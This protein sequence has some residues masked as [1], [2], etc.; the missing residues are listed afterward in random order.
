MEECFPRGGTLK[1]SE[2]TATKKRQ[3]EDD[4]LFSTYR[5]EAEETGKKKKKKQLKETSKA[6][7]HEKGSFA[8][9]KAVE[10][11]NYKDLSV[12]M[13]F[14]GCIKE[15]KD[16]ELV[17]SLPYNLVGFVQATNICE[18][19][20][21]LLNEQVKKEEPV[22]GLIP[23]PNL[24]S[25]GMLVRC[26]ISNLETTS[27]GFNSIKLSLNPKLIHG[28]LAPSSV[29][30]GMYLTGLVS[31][32][33]DHGYLIDLGIAGTKAFLPRHKADVYINQTNK[34]P[35]L[36]VGQ[37]LDTVIDEVKNDGRILR[38]SVSQSDVTAA[39][40]T[41]EQ[42]WTINNLLPGLVVKAQ[43]Q[44]I[45]HDHIAVS[46]LSSYTGIVDFLHLEPKKANV[47]QSDQL[48]KACILWI[49]KS[50]KTIRLTFRKTFLQ[51]GRLIKQ[52]S[53][54][55]IGTVHEKCTVKALFKH[56]GAMFELDG[57][58]MAFALKYHLISKLSS[59]LNRYK[60]G[61]VHT[62]RVVA[63]S[64]M[65][66]TIL[67]SL[68]ETVIEEP[69][70]KH[71]DIQAGQ[72]LEGTV[73]KIATEGITVNI[74]KRISG[75]IPN[76]HMADITLNHPEKRYT[77]GKN[78]KCRVLNVDPLARKLILTRKKTM[79]NSKLPIIASF[80][81]AKPGMITHG[82]IWAVK[83]FGCIV[84]FYNDVHG[85]VP[86]RELSSHYIPVIQDAFYK[87]QV[88]R[89][90][91]LECNREKE[92]LLLSFKI[93]EENENGEPDNK[94][95]R[96]TLSQW[97]ESGKIVDVRIAS[98]TD[99]ELNVL[100]L[101]EESP[102]VLPKVHLSDHAANCELLF[103][104]LKEGDVLSRVMCL[105][106]SKG[107]TILTRKT[108]L[109]SCV[110]KGS[111]AKDFSEVQVGMYLTGF[112][113]NIM[114]YGVF[115]EF[116]HGLV[117]LVP[118]S[119]VSDKFVTEI[120][121]HFVQGQ[122]VV[123]KVTNIDEQKK[124]FLLTLKMS[125]CAP[126]DC[127]AD[128]FSQ[129]GQCCSELQFCKSLMKKNEKLDEGET[130]YSVIPG[131]NLILVVEKL[132]DNG[133]VLFSTSQVP[134][135]KKISAVQ[136]KEQEKPLTLGQKVKAVILHVDILKAHVHVSMEEALL[137]KC[138]ENFAENSVHSAVIQH[139]S[140]EFAVA[141]LKDTS[142]LVA[143][144]LKRHFNDTFRFE[145]ERLSVGQKISVTLSSMD[146]DQHGI[147]FAVQ[148]ASSG[149]E[150]VKMPLNLTKRKPLIG[151]VITGTV[152]S[153][154]PISV[155]VSITDKLTGN[156][157][158]SQIVE[159][160]L[161]GA[162]PTSKLRP[163]QSVTCRVI[164]GRD[165][166]TH[167]FLP[168]THPHLMKSVLELSILPSLLN[169]EVKVEK[170]K[171]LNTYSSGDTVTCYVVKYNKEK[172]CLEVEISPGIRGTVE[173]LL[174]SSSAKVLKRPEK[175]F[176][177]G[178]AL[179]AT[180]VDV[181]DARKK[182]SLSLIDLDAL[183][184]GCITFGCVKSVIPSTGLQITIPF[185][186]T[187]RASFFQLNDCYDEISL[188]KFA[189]G[190]LVRCCILSVG[191]KIDL[192]LRESRLNPGSVSKQIDEDLSSIDCLKEG[193]LIKGFVSAVTDKGVFFRISSSIDGHIL[194]KN[195]TSYYVNEI[196]MY[197]KHIPE[198]KLLTAK[199][200]SIAKEENHIEL[201][202]LSNDTGNPDVIPESD[203]YSLRRKKGEKKRRRTN[204][205]REV[206]SSKK[207]KSQVSQDDEDSGVEVHY[208]EQ[209]TENEEKKE[210]SNKP[211]APRLQVSS[212]FSWDVSLNTLKTSLIDGKES[213][214]DS[215]E[216]E[217]EC[218]KIQKTKSNQKKQG[219]EKRP[220]GKE[221]KDPSQQPQSINEFERLVLSSPNISANWIQ[222][223]D[224]HLQATELEQ[225]RAV[226]ER[227]LQT[228]YFRE[229]QEKLNVWVA[230]L[231]MENT[232]G[233]EETLLK[234]F[235]RAV[236]YNDP[237]KAFQHLVEIYIK[238]EKFKEADELF[239]TMIKR[240]KQEKSVYWKNAAFLLKQGQSEA[241]HRLL[242]RAMKCLPEKEHV[243]V[244]SK[245]AQL[246][247]QLGDPVRA[248]ALF[249]STLSSYPKRT[250][251]WSVYID[252]MV[253]HGNQKEI[254]DIFERV[255]HLSLA[256]KRIKFFFKRYLE[257]EKKHGNEKTVQAVKEKALQYVEAKSS[258]GT[259]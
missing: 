82:F 146:A 247:F 74:A 89:V 120:G 206:K 6:S 93:I 253:K 183:T 172:Q 194:F 7:Q 165:L 238:S 219:V 117:G 60:E 90:R 67:L 193:Q 173:Q 37:Y 24:Y 118:I 230:M 166:K 36:G 222:Y 98:K 256:A 64:P 148:N 79:I 236:Q 237:L 8:K 257:Y 244:I 141:S 153:I 77:P 49:D 171:P 119:E 1:K 249:E 32:E 160:V 114:P 125:E 154:K 258:V 140:E 213:S 135:A 168:I 251:I 128:G 16:F 182:L 188:E 123:A 210:A 198:G 131:K 245:F 102:A 25:P 235:G 46:F 107:Q 18:A 109:I 158:A 132:E 215:E 41:D 73:E 239:N 200:I 97:K 66:E 106:T 96:R 185:G 10:L 174:L 55:W 176:R 149:R 68:K 99:A 72:F 225:A 26:A 69:F 4:N 100:I 129:I 61:T 180:V 71:E 162:L 11:L 43:I 13:L 85:L 83:D 142:K 57:E 94:R 197:K 138:K 207:K 170:H 192:S 62:G 108:A 167:K 145:S 34:G 199:I 233:T 103:H 252:M 232:Y 88:V 156:I 121:D 51:P 48:V 229:E 87:G 139:L 159:N 124:R 214:S 184:E 81:D 250:D 191:N 56:A 111:C 224:F 204:S 195:V 243:E 122:T 91:V 47:Y 9:V 113:R 112:V 152:K 221:A 29:H 70:W 136:H 19:Y 186:K 231:N 196:E 50:S 144:P 54:N 30:K 178:Q 143:V 42:K 39:I 40:A 147:Q 190:M 86:A 223:M 234:V 255:I 205:E 226:A 15:V 157:H 45:F 84:K 218:P 216:D 65:E 21:K 20:T 130:I 254:R 53:S 202:L 161:A 104:C 187:G 155:L 27:G 133:S 201:S 35:A 80:H 126:D 220:A 95:E 38:L 2:E 241:A 17:I 164:G 177:P 209:K 211:P 203:G 151:E 110:E 181:E 5:E 105:N 92:T 75:L 127:S 12:G 44:K 240:F 59:D 163:K 76:L 212:G 242:Q 259:S 23:L 175:H 137:K 134:G 189:A 227:A 116:L 179:T 3:R 63:F 101:P 22:E 52:L 28:D 58:T 248:K 150:K 246:E 33:E 228:I 31:S 169:T 14:L 78:I 115:V 217:E 208:R